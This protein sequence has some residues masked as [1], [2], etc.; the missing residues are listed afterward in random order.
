M[1]NLRETRKSV[2]TVKSRGINSPTARKRKS[3]VGKI[4][5][6]SSAW[7]LTTSESHALPSLEAEGEKAR[8]REKGKAK[9]STAIACDLRKSS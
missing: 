1:M 8:G 5:C 6:A 4:S 3:I 9:E 2:T 7:N